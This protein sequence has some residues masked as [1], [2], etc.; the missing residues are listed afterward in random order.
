VEH[1]TANELMGQTKGENTKY[2]KVQ[3]VFME[4]FQ[5]ECTVHLPAA[6][7][8]NLVMF[9]NV[10][11]SLKRVRTDKWFDGNNE[12]FKAEVIQNNILVE[13][14]LISIQNYKIIVFRFTLVRC[15]PT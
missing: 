1:S 12:S 13:G 8:K 11:K 4:Q 9:K 6:L 15:L 14:M 3:S 5:Q 2:S 10:S 7:A